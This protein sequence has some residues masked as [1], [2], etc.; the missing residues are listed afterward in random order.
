MR[1][2]VYP[3]SGLVQKGKEDFGAWVLPDTRS[4]PG[5]ADGLGCRRQVCQL[6]GGGV[7]LGTLGLYEALAGKSM[8][9]PLFLFAG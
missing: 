3:L 2:P 6:A 5:E 1:F 7:C 4:G 8:R 9:A